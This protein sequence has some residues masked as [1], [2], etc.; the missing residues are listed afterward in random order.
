LPMQP[1]GCQAG[2]PI[3]GVAALRSV[4]QAS[5]ACLAPAG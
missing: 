4:G 1:A 2:S 5:R 3:H